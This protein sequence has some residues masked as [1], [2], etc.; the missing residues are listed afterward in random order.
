[1]TLLDN[2]PTLGGGVLQMSASA[3]ETDQQR[4]LVSI[5]E[6]FPLRK[7]NGH[8]EYSDFEV[9]LDEAG[10]KRL[11]DALSRWLRKRRAM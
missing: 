11:R 9:I 5:L 7:P 8:E 4:P 1:M 6:R 3:G 2:L 10:A